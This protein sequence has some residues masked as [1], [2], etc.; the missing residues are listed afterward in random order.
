MDTRNQSRRNFLK[1]A[2]QL[3]VLTG[4][5]SLGSCL[6]GCS[7]D[8]PVSSNTGVKVTLI[9]AN[10][11]DLAN[12]GGFI[13]RVF[14]GNNNNNAVIVVRTAEK[15]FQSM[16]TLC[17]HQGGSIQEPSGN[18]ATCNLHAGQYSIAEGNFA[19]NV[20]G[21]QGPTL[22]TFLTEYDEAAGTVT[23]TF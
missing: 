17:G 10:E 22:R 23:I 2:G 1:A 6:G 3:T 13:R 5:I 8:D 11:P 4:V 16:T 12:T 19:Q 21:E 15:K 20:G 7:S 14:A 9:L 18:K